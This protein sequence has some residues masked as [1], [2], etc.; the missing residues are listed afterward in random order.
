MFDALVS[1]P[2]LADAALRGTVLALMGL[3]WI[4]IMVNIV[5]LR[6]FSKMTSF[7]FVMTVA[8]GSLLA[9]IATVSQWTG[10]VQGV[11]AATA[12]FAAQYAVAKIRKASDGFE[13]FIQNQPVLL[14]HEGEFIETALVQT[15]VSK[16]DLIAK[17]RE[18]NVL[19]LSEVRA[20][21]LEATGDVSVL[22]GDHLEKL[23]ISGVHDC[24]D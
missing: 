23:L 11:A 1:W 3:V 14:M 17:L 5:G 12:L 16:D 2:D 9:G 18:A 21:V 19:K 13:S 7:D 6:S 22:H 24:R 4:I 20:A 10:F 15:R 8:M